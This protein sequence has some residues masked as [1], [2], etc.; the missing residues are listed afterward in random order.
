MENLMKKFLLFLSFGISLLFSPYLI[1]LTF[2][3]ALSFIFAKDLRQFLPSLLV[4]FLFLALIPGAYILW[5]LET[6]AIYDLHISHLKERKWPFIIIAISALVGSIIFYYL[7]VKQ[8]ILVLATAYTVNA[9]LI[10]VITLFWKISIHMALFSG[11]VTVLIMLFG[12]Q[13]WPFYLFL[14]PLGWAR[15]YRKNHTLAHIFLGAVL[16]FAVTLLI[17]YFF[18]YQIKG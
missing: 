18:G 14:L 5:G 3:S 4:G 1:F 12:I 9:A 2:F 17:Y 7:D 11:M 16:G 6:K 13:F 15:V 8:P 10:A